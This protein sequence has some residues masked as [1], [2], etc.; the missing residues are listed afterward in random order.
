MTKR[1][2]KPT[3]KVELSDQ[4]RLQLQEMTDEDRSEILDAIE[5]IASGEL[6]GEPLDIESLPAE[7]QEEMLK[8]LENLSRKG[9]S[10]T[11]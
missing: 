7:E 11:S 6:Q 8:S 3:I 10:A 9:P 2:E 1:Q 5:K 4:V